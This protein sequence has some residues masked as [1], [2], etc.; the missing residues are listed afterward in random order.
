MNTLNHLRQCGGDRRSQFTVCN[1]WS[2]MLSFV[3]NDSGVSYNEY[4]L[5]KG[6]EN[7]NL[8]FDWKT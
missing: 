5:L 6:Y 2:L 3:W 1:S 4:C 8:K 7:T